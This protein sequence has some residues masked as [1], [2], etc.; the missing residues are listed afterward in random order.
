MN[1]EEIAYACISL[2]NQGKFREAYEGYY[3]EDAVKVEPLAWG[4]HSNEVAGSKNMAAHEEWLTEDWLTINSVAISEGP[5]IGAA[6]FSVIIKSDFTMRDTGSRH[7]FREVGVYTV[8]DGKIVVVFTEPEDREV[9]PRAD[10]YALAAEREPQPGDVQ[11]ILA[12]G[13]AL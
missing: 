7:I 4:Q 11:K 5:F 3:S 10:E 8:E 12:P 6:G 2:W 13:P 9:P 1:T